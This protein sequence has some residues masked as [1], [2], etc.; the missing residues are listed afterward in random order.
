VA[1]TT[2]G[3]CP[4]T[5]QPIRKPEVRS[6]LRRQTALLD[7]CPGFQPYSLA[8]DIGHIAVKQPPCEAR[9]EDPDFGRLLGLRAGRP[10]VLSAAMRLWR[11]VRGQRRPGSQS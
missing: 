3:L 2:T 9:G 1:A 8:G 11:N 4:Q 10:S 5:D 7:G 6:G